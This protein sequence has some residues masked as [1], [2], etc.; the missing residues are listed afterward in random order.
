MEKEI[1]KSYDAINHT[2]LHAMKMPNRQT[3]LHSFILI[4]VFVWIGFVCS[5]SFMEAWLKFQAP[6]VTLSIGLGIGR[7]IFSALNKMEWVLAGVIAAA[8]FFNG[9]KSKLGTSLFLYIPLAILILQT[10]W[11]LPSLNERAENIIQGANV[12]SSFVHF[13]YIFFEFVK[14]LSLLGLGICA[15]NS[16][17]ALRIEKGNTETM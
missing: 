15:I 1:K 12:S 5:I 17:I 9:R 6:N 10:L 8:V 4:S 16:L 2:L 14:V 7:L 11:L 3:I 13:Y